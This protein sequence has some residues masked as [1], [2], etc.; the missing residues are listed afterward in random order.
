[1]D[2]STIPSTLTQK[3]SLKPKEQRAARVR[4]NQQ[5]HRAKTKAHIT[6]LEEQLERTHALLDTALERIAELTAELDQVRLKS[7]GSLSTSG[8]ESSPTSC[9]SSSRLPQEGNHSTKVLSLLESTSDLANK[10]V[11]A[12]PTP[13]SPRIGS[14]SWEAEYDEALKYTG[15]LEPPQPGESTTR[16]SAA[17]TIIEQ[18]NF[19]RLDSSAIDA[20]LREGFRQATSKEDGCRVENCSLFALLDFISCT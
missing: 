2:S 17:Y 9:C 13:K 8:F 10:T 14:L 12:L 11:Q 4:L 15:H 7:A 18:Q 5:R 20:W 16:C 19:R 6:N 3:W 1:M